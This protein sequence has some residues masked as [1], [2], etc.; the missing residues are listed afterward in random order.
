MLLQRKASHFDYKQFTLL[1]LPL[2]ASPMVCSTLLSERDV[3]QMQPNCRLLF[4]IYFPSKPK[5]EMK[6]IMGSTF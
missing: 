5:R 2:F 6:N 4:N 3:T 1:P